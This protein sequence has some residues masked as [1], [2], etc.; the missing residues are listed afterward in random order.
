MWGLYS[1]LQEDKTEENQ[2]ERTGFQRKIDHFGFLGGHIHGN[3]N[4]D[5]EVFEKPLEE[6]SY[7]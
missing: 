2:I 4:A 1:D 3:P 5:D 6:I 7:E